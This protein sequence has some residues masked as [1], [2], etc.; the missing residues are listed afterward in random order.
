MSLPYLK[1]SAGY[2]IRLNFLTWH[3]VP[4]NQFQAFSSLISYP[5][6]FPGLCFIHAIPSSPE[7]MPSYP[8]STWQTGIK[9][10]RPSLCYFTSVAFP[11]FPNP[12]FSLI[13]TY[14]MALRVCCCDMIMSQ[15]SNYELLQGQRL[16]NFNLAHGLN[17]FNIAFSLK[18]VFHLQCP[19]HEN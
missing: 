13:K 14:L 5:I 1:I 16:Y 4:T 8:V 17:E 12:Q 7:C 2:A 6:A 11:N 18:L 3:K 15:P 9:S 19:W 10:V